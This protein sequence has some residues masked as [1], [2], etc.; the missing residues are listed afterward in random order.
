MLKKLRTHLLIALI[1][2]IVTLLQQYLF[3]YSKGLTIVWLTFGKY[4]AT[5]GF[6]LLATFIKPIGLRYFFLG[7]VFLLNFFQMAHLSYFGT[8]ILPAEF[9]LF[10]TE[11]HEVWGTL[12]AELHHIGVPL[13]FTLPPALL[14]WLLLKK[15][16]NLYGS[17]WI[18]LLFCLYMIYNPIRTMVTGN[19]W[20]GNH[21]P[22]N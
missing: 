14:G 17:K 7:F 15:N 12:F 2:L 9:Y 19:T 5:F 3:Y 8:Q 10:F 21:L 22:E 18:G 20:D 4:L 11:S 13:L 6:F 1:F 16:T